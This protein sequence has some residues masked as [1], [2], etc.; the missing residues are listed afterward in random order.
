MVK[1]PGSVEI[2]YWLTR[3]LAT[4]RGLES[5]FA[6]VRTEEDAM[7]PRSVVH[8]DSEILSGTPVFVGT[9]VPVRILFEYLAAGD[10]LEEFLDAFPS[11]S[12]DQAV[13]AL[14]LASSILAE[15]AR[16]PR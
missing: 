11:V 12:K 8:S 16:S 13:A 5:R 4:S 7:D 2:H 15:G 9:R 14:D 1:A 6:I 3:D 10:S